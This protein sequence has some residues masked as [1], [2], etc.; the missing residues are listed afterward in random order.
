MPT[1]RKPLKVIPQ[2]KRASSAAR[3]YDA[4]WRKVRAAYLAANPV[5]VVCER[6]GRVVPATEVDHIKAHRGND[7][8]FW[9]ELNWQ[10]LC[11]PCHSEKTVKEDG[12][13]GNAY[14]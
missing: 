4:R 2:A 12:G 7:T 3:G 10:A 11:K 5:C 6:R 8:L 14:R 13:F 9:D 1:K